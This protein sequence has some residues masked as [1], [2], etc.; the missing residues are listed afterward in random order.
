MYYMELTKH[1]TLLR[2]VSPTVDDYLSREL[3]EEDYY[4]EEEGELAYN[5][6]AKDVLGLC[7]SIIIDELEAIGIHFT[8]DLDTLIQDIY[9]CGYVYLIRKFVDKPYLAKL[10]QATDTVEAVSKYIDTDEQK[11]NLLEDIVNIVN[12]KSHDYELT[13]MEYILPQTYTDELFVRYL[14]RVIVD[15]NTPDAIITK[16]LTAVENYTKHI[17]T[18]RQLAYRYTYAVIGTLNLEPQLDMAKIAKLL[19]D[20]DRDKI[21]PDT[22][23]LYSL[24]DRENVPTNL[25]ATKKKYMDIH[26]ANSPHHVEYWLTDNPLKQRFTL[27]NLILLVAHHVEPGTTPEEFQDEVEDTISKLHDILNDQYKQLAKKMV[28]V[29]QPLMANDPVVQESE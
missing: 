23:A 15:I 1:F 28:S 17:A 11:P 4:D 12:I 14:K 13:E 7:Y 18:L 3:F 2:D 27:D 10:L 9:T 8:M 5:Y 6:S 26:H 16:D 25:Y 22:V 24:I 20:Y 21:R 19:R 29:I